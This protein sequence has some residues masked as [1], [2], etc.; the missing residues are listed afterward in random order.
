MI[1]IRSCNLAA[2]GSWIRRLLVPDNSKWKVLTWFML[3][4][5]IE[6]LQN[7]NCLELNAQ[8]KSAFYTQILR[9]WAEINSFN[10]ITLMEIIN[11]NLVENKFIRI[12]NKPVI[13]TFLGTNNQ[14]KLKEMKIKDIIDNNW[15]LITK[16]SLEQKLNEK[17][18]ILK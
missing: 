14:I 13:D 8:G 11:Q 4:I 7:N 6:K 5:N 1:D 2:K 10:P 15:K 18:S 16:N 17:F 9:A 3:N 12:E